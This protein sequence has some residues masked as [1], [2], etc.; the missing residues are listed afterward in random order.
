MKVMNR[1][2]KQ[3]DA[4]YNS[5]LPIENNTAELDYSKAFY[6]PYHPKA[7]KMFQ[8]LR[9][10]LSINCVFKKTSTLGN[11]FFKRRPIQDIRDRTHVVYQIPCVDCP[12]RYIGQTKRK[13][14]TRV[15]E[16][17]KSCEGDLTSVIPNQTYDN[18]IQYHTATTGHAF[19]FEGP[20]ILIQERNYFRRMVLEGMLIRI[21]IDSLVNV[22]SGVSIDKCWMPFYPEIGFTSP[23]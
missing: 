13:L 4:E 11:Y 12:K 5:W 20:E 7:S 19:D 8:K 15:A 10:S 17:R 18:G 22:K 3:W 6:A 1:K 14:R 2:S 21:N 9:K 16:H 23:G